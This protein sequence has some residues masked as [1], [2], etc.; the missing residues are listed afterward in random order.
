MESQFNIYL[1]SAD[2]NRPPIS[3]AVKEYFITFIIENVL[4]KKKLII[5]GKWKVILAIIFLSEGKR[6]SSAEIFLAKGGPRT[7]TNE[8]VRLYEIIIPMKVIKEAEA[9]LLRTIELIY[10]AI[11]IFFTTTYKK[12]T[13]EFMDNLWK[14]V[15]LK[16][17]L[18]LP[19]PA[20]LE[21]QKYVG[22]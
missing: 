4:A 8:G 3:N 15:D 6:Y 10:E 16:Y 13:P 19:Y 5:G 20:P 7:I 9:P 12:V 1:S 21:E 18:S 17:L 14:E 22:D 2:G 11:K